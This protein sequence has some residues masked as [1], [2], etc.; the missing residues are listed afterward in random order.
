MRVAFAL[1]PL[2]RLRQNLL[3]QAPPRHQRQER[4]R[5][6]LLPPLGQALP[7]HDRARCRQRDDRRRRWCGSC[8]RW[9]RIPEVGIL[10]TQP[11]KV[12]GR[13]LFRRVLQFSSH[14]YGALFSQGCSLAQM[15]SGSYW[16]H[17]AIIRVAP[18]IE[19]C[20]LPLPARARPEPPPCLEPR[21]GR[22]RADAPRRLRSLDRLRGAGQ[23]R[24]GSAEPERHAHARPPL[25]RGQPAA[26]LVSLR[27][28]HR[29]R[30]PAANLDRAHGLSLLADL[31]ALPHRQLLQRLLAHAVSH[32]LGRP[33]G[34]R[35]RARPP[36]RSCFSGSPWC[37]LFMPRV[38]GVVARL[39][40]TQAL[41]RRRPPA[42][43]RPA[44]KPDFH[45][46]RA[47]VDDLPYPLRDV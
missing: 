39:H 46:A 4:Q 16:G 30:Q 27:A 43:Q 6:R 5:G 3:S 15:S 32:A 9:R 47:G 33:G 23:L 22:G 14:A 13:S 34:P 20:G 36:A 2:Q 42:R 25:V 7:L 28:R 10:Q 40:G 45:P 35:R 21:H 31:A 17:N 41:R 24:G 8:A 19:H 37:L 44:G 29:S 1:P 12:L 38:L 11:Y 26:F 18:F